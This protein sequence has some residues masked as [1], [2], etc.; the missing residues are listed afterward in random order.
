MDKKEQLQN[1]FIMNFGYAYKSF[2]LSKLMGHVVALLISSPKPVALEDIALT[3]NRSKGPISQLTRRLRDKNLIRRVW[4]PTSRK[5]FYEIQPEIFENAFRNNLDLI[6][7][8][9]NLAKQY[10][11]RI[12]KEDIKDLEVL[13]ERLTEMSRFYELMDKHYKNFL[14]EWELERNNK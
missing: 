6:R 8:N 9:T 12:K 7:N 10:K 14:D 5:D 11:D 13:N 2:G 4:Q 3:L 1:D